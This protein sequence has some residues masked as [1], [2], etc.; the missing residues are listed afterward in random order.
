MA[1]K[2]TLNQIRKLL[3][4]MV[5]TSGEYGETD[6]DSESTENIENLGSIIY[7]ALSKLTNIY[8]FADETSTRDAI[9]K[10]IDIVREYVQGEF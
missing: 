6:F 1:N 4:A 8:D 7:V 5:K 3:D 10:Q 2:L 9:Y